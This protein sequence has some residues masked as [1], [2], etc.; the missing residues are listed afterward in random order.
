[1]QRCPLPPS[2][3]LCA[4]FCS[5]AFAAPS[6]DPPVNV[7]STNGGAIGSAAGD[8]NKDGKVEFISAA[9]RA[10]SD[11]HLRIYQW[12]EASS[13]FNVIDVFDPASRQD[14]FGG[15]LEI[16]DMN[17]D[18][19][20]D[21]L[22]PESNNTNGAGKVSW[23]ENPDG[24]LTGNWTEHV[25]TT[26]PGGA[27]GVEHMSEIDAGDIDGNGWVDV[28]VRDVSH[29]FFI[30]L[31]QDGGAG[32]QPRIDVTAN[33]REGL[34]LWNPDGDDDLDVLLNG[35]WFETPANPQTEAFTLHL[36]KGAEAW[37]PAGNSSNEQRDYACQITLG[38][39][40]ADGRMDFAITNSEELANAASTDSKP[41][42]VQVLLAP[43]D[44]INDTWT[45]VVLHAQYFS[46]HSCEVGDI[47]S[48]GDLDVIS[49]ISQVG[50]DSTSARLIAFLNDGGGGS[51][52]AHTINT[53]HY[54]YQAS[55]GDADGDGDLDLFAPHNWNSGTLRYYENAQD[56]ATDPPLP[57]SGLQATTI[58]SARIDL[59]WA[60]NADNEAGYHILRKTTGAYSTVASLSAN[61][62][63]Y[64]DTGLAPE[65]TYF[66]QVQAINNVGGAF[67]NEASAT[68]ETAPP[69]AD[70]LIAHWR[71][72]EEAGLMA[73][74]QTGA[75]DA[76]L[77]GDP[78]WQPE[79][80]RIAGAL[81]LDGDDRAQAPAID[82]AGSALTLA[83]WVRP[84]SYSGFA[85]EARYISKATSTNGSDHYWMLGNYED[86]TAL[87]FRLQTSSG[88]TATLISNT[89]LLPLNEWS[90]IAA[91]YDGVTM[92][93]FLNGVEV[94]SQAK[95]GA[96]I[97]NAGVSVGLGNQPTGAGERGLIGRLD[98]VRI[99][100]RALN[101]TELEALINLASNSAPE[102]A[103]ASPLPAAQFSVAESIP[104]SGSA[105]DPED[106]A[107]S[108]AQLLWSSSLD[109]ELGTGGELTVQ[110]LSLGTHQLTLRA[111][112]SIGL[113][114][115]S[116]I[117]LNILSDADSDGL[118][119]EFENAHG[120]PANVPASMT[121][122]T[123]GDG[124]TDYEEWLANTHPL[125]AHSVFRVQEATRES[126]GHLTLQWS[127]SV[128]R[129]YT[130]WQSTDLEV[131]TPLISVE[132][133]PPS[134]S[135]STPLPHGPIFLQI[136]VSR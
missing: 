125:D 76:S 132:A 51:F 84:T 17:N 92:K 78:V 49:G 107:L 114:N 61:A 13:G 111:E 121:Q 20:P 21:I 48:D 2:P 106:G 77:S 83:A 23:F 89:G 134:Q 67:S 27:N 133:S 93:L 50:A 99:Y 135:L 37:Y 117:T 69:V 41:K 87:R 36:I 100:D 32:W 10:S 124:A 43:V 1:M 127:S 68:T 35:A 128:G 19:W 75:F 94:A 34:E 6:F 26:W 105:T 30:L 39:F 57:P 24:V 22:V 113:W 74:D 81:E 108:G 118:P 14:R 64:S 90:H 95:T 66:Y 80:G 110:G 29:G 104:L 7:S 109:G 122:D 82:L 86:G 53:Q 116:T 98:D 3:L 126:A 59:S 40:N 96:I 54:I 16:A 88:G 130:L 12:N 119:D 52:T 79:G 120:L 8:L 65:T 85:A 71:F 55:L 11:S 15:D 4:L 103:I 44:P 46:W 115:K 31:R 62:T 9:S 70:N 25:I 129:R 72:D 38:D 131:F 60:D 97:A 102:A 18:G 47:D 123:D 101:E 112:D 91:T 136:S 5:A 42:G 33:P 45:K 56:I 73:V 63:S 28:V 58:S